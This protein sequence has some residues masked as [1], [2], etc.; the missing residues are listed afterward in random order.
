MEQ[1][2]SAFGNPSS[3]CVAAVVHAVGFEAKEKPVETAAG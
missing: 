1:S 3:S 2:Y